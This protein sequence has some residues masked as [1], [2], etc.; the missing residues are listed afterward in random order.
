M[1]ILDPEIFEE[2]NGCRTKRGSVVY[3]DGATGK[4]MP[5][6]KTPYAPEECNIYLNPHKDRLLEI[7]KT[8]FFSDYRNSYTK[9]SQCSLN[10]PREL[11]KYL[12]NPD[13]S[14]R[15]KEKVERYY[16][17]VISNISI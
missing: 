10:L 14:L 13:V 12:V 6:V 17:K 9:C 2:V 16:R 3:I 4:V 5:C 7:L 15:D 11:D 1:P 8:E